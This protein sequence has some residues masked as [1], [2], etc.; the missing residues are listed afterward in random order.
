MVFLCVRTCLPFSEGI[1]HLWI[2]G[3]TVHPLGWVL[4]WAGS[5]NRE[6]E[7]GRL[8]GSP[9]QLAG[10]AGSKEGGLPN[11]YIGNE[12]PQ[13][14]YCPH[15]TGIQSSAQIGTKYCL[16]FTQTGYQNVSW[17][18]SFKYQE[19]TASYD[20]VMGAVTVNTRLSPSAQGTKSCDPFPFTHLLLCSI[21]TDQ[22]VPPDSS[23]IFAQNLREAG[24]NVTTKFYDGKTHSGPMIEDLMTPTLVAEDIV[25]DIIRITQEGTL[26][27]ENETKLPRRHAFWKES[28]LV[29]VSMM[30]MA[31]LVNPFS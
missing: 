15:D 8:L 20:T 28:Q 12:V 13:P 10:G 22:T 29:P 6:Q 24:H 19:S 16:K 18:G 9:S 14:G 26:R 4:K 7:V 27:R 17:A 2:G 25:H 30:W 11:G 23:I 3:L 31:R 5:K 1:I 21:S